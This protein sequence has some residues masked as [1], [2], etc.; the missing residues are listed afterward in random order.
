ML[1]N[2]YRQLGELE[3]QGQLLYAGVPTN[4]GLHGIPKDGIGVVANHGQERLWRKGVEL[5]IVALFIGGCMIGCENNVNEG[6]G[7]LRQIN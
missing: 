5:L 6:I 7:Y 4:Q 3:D 1:R 2:L